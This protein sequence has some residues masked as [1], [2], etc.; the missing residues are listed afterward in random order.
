VQGTRPLGAIILVKFN[1]FSV[2]GAV[3]PH[4][5]TDQGK[6]WHGGAD[7]RSSPPCQILPWSVQRVCNCIWLHTT[8]TTSTDTILIIFPHIHQFCKNKYLTSK[9]TSSHFMALWSRIT[10]FELE[11]SQRRDLLEQPLDFYELDVLPATQPVMSKH[12]RKQENPDLT[13]GTLPCQMQVGQSGL[14]Q[15]LLRWS[16]SLP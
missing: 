11:L 15:L 12:Y 16:R 7:L 8:V 4:P 10:R 1:F 6:I 9:Q 2:L 14:Q 3:N 13:N 5:W